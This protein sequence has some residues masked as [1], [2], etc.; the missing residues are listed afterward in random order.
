MTVPPRVAEIWEAVKIRLQS[1]RMQEILGGPGRVFVVQELRL[2]TATPPKHEAWGR[3]VIVPTA[4]ASP[5]P[6]SGTHVRVPGFLLRA[7]VNKPDRADNYNPMISLEA[8]LSEGFKLTEGWQ[9]AALK[10]A[11]VLYPIQRTHS[12][13]ASPVWD[14]ER[15]LW[16]LSSRHNITLA[17]VA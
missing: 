10:Y 16:L 13:A 7:E 17:P 5:S 4:P 1:V 14:T 9:P 11:R 15:R 12:P 2:D 6:G 3:L 8:A